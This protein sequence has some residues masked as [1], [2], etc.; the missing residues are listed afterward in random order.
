MSQIGGSIESEA[1]DSIQPLLVKNV[2]KKMSEQLVSADDI[3]TITIDAEG[4]GGQF[5]GAK[6]WVKTSSG[7]SYLLDANAAGPVCNLEGLMPGR[8]SD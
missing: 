7:G 4:T 5:S 8:L 3:R 6:V 1:L 2:V